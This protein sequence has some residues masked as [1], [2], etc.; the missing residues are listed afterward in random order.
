MLKVASKTAQRTSLMFEASPFNLNDAKAYAAWR[1]KKIA[2][3]QR[4]LKALTVKITDWRLPSKAEIIA[5]AAHC[6]NSNFAI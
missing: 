3:A 5:V 2:S 1:A 6:E 4:G